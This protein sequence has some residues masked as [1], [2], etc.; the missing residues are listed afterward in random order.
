MTTK[1]PAETLYQQMKQ[2]IRDN[3]L[4]IGCP[5]KQE[6]LS[7]Q[8]AVSRIPIRDVLQR[9]KNEGW[10]IQSGKRGVQIN[11]LNATEAEDLY[12]MRVHLEP[13]LLGYAMSNLNHQIIGKAADTLEQLKQPKLTLQKHGDLNWQFHACLYQAAQRPTLFDN[14]SHLHQLCSRYIGFQT[15]ELDY[16]D[17]S[18]EEHY[19][20]L[21]AIKTRQVNQAQQILKQHISEAGK[22]LVAY[23]KSH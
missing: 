9:L 11:P 19:Q 22:A 14:V 1:Q 8:Y 15:L 21:E 13:L 4:P 20:L 5:L 12:I 18:Q 10:L 3:K 23:L 7:Q 16:Q 2:D 17:N 6:Q